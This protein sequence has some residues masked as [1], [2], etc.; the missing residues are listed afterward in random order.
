M[1][2]VG[3]QLATWTAKGQHRAVVER[4]RA[5]LAPVCAKLPAGDSQR[6]ACD[7]VLKKVA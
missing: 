7:G 1:Q 2:K 6:A 3:D 5:Q 4:L